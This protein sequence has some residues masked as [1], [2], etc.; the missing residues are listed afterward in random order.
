MEISITLRPK[1]ELRQVTA[2]W[3]TIQAGVEAMFPQ[4]IQLPQHTFFTGGVTASVGKH[5]GVSA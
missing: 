3:Q 5:T 2:A 1:T 4:D